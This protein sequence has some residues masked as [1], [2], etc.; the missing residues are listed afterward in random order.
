MVLLEDESDAVRVFVLSRLN[1]AQVGSFFFVV[2][3]TRTQLAIVPLVHVVA[4][5]SQA[6][7]AKLS[8]E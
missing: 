3:V 2:A 4:D 6:L 8:P 1:T 7:F 5:M